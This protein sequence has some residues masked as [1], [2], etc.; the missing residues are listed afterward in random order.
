MRFVCVITLYV[1]KTTQFHNVTTSA[2]MTK[3][4]KMLQHYLHAAGRYI[5]TMLKEIVRRGLTTL[6]TFLHMASLHLLSCVIGM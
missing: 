6:L 4:P 1:G 2:C 5:C 3:I